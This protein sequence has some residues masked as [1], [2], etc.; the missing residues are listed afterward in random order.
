MIMKMG[1]EG[2][3]YDKMCMW[4]WDSVPCPSVGNTVFPEYGGVREALAKNGFWFSY[5]E[6]SSF[7]TNMAHPPMYGADGKDP[8]TGKWMTPSSYEVQQYSGQRPSFSMPAYLFVTYTPPSMPR[9]QFVFNIE[10]SYTTWWQGGFFDKFRISEFYLN[11]RFMSHDRLKVTIG[12]HHSGWQTVGLYVGGNMAGS[13]LGVNAIF[14]TLVG[15]SMPGMPVPNLNIHFDITKHIYSLTGVETSLA[16]NASQGEANYSSPLYLP[17]SITGKNGVAST[18]AMFYQ[19][20]DY[21][22][23]LA[24]GVKKLWTRSVVFYN[25]THYSDYRYFNP[26]NADFNPLA[27]SK[28]NWCISN[29][30]DGQVTQP[31]KILPF[32]GLYAGFTTQYAPPHQNPYTQYYESRAYYVG[33]LKARPFDMI[34]LMINNLEFSKTFVKNVELGIAGEATASTGQTNISPTYVALIRPG[35]WANVG[36]EYTVHPTIAPITPNSFVVTTGLALFF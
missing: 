1:M 34:T 9:T 20:F 22:R 36:L 21:N 4:D 12:Y 24:P 3:K 31:D 7:T 11:Q 23:Q 10:E 13:L 30:I 5:F 29:G 15:Q 25:A 6:T 28:D 2:A 19:E 26:A 35:V 14:P 16:P 18:K 33:L 32:R 27:E 8:V 17:F